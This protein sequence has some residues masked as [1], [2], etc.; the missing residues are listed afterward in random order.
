M[1]LIA[2]HGCVVKEPAKKQTKQKHGSKDRCIQLKMIKVVVE[3]VLKCKNTL[4]KVKFLHSKFQ[5]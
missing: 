4:L 1:H 5:Y 3:E 2:K